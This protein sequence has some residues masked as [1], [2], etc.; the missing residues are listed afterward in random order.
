MY[1][2][3]SFTISNDSVIPVPPSA[4]S[5][6]YVHFVSSLLPMMAGT[7]KANSLPGSAATT[8][9]LVVQ[10]TNLFLLDPLNRAPTVGPVAPSIHSLLTFSGLHSP[11]RVTSDTRSYSFSGGALTWTCASPRV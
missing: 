1:Q 4:S 8:R 5:K 6:R 11:I 9:G 7:T 10:R 3:R 2:G